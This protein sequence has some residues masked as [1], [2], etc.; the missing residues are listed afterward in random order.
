MKPASNNIVLGAGYLYLD[1]FDSDGNR[2]GERY[3]GD[4]PGFEID[5][6]ST[7]VEVFGSDAP[8]AEKIR[9]I[10]TQVNRTAN[11][12][13]RNISSDNLALFLIGEATSI[14]Q[15]NTAV[16]D[17]RIT[18]KTGQWYQLGQTDTDPVGVRDVSSV[19]VTI[20]P[21][22]AATSATVDDDY[23]VEAETGRLY[24]VP[25]GA[26]SDDDEIGVD[27]TPGDVEFSQVATDNL[28][29][30]EGAIRFVAAN[31]E[32]DNR[33]AYLPSVTV[34]PN[35]AMAWKSRDT[36]ASMSLACGINTKG[37]LSQVYINGRP[38]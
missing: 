10:A 29:A 3:L 1:K 12:T 25:G 9:D 8:I 13:C 27:Y 20:D 11:I 37:N 2:T 24:I 5:V 23:T 4:T 15:G 38:A 19:S 26:I 32:G 6:Q 31:T 34:R 16:T 35:G 22:G 18:A 33:D 7:Q 21:D 30:K 14:D 28:G 17:E 36:I